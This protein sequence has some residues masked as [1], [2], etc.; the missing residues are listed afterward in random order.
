MGK[1]YLYNIYIAYIM[2]L[3]LIKFQNKL[4]TERKYKRMDRK[5]IREIATAFVEQVQKSPE[6]NEAKISVM[7]DLLDATDFAAKAQLF[8]MGRRSHDKNVVVTYQ[9]GEPHKDATEWLTM[10][11]CFAH[12]ALYDSNTRAS[13]V[14]DE[15]INQ[16]ENRQKL[17]PQRSAGS[18][19]VGH[20][21]TGNAARDQ[22]MKNRGIH[23]NS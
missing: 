22:M 16:V 4:T 11:S 1:N 18:C 10:V 17:N 6:L 8:A 5:Q 7:V 2:I 15:V 3:G 12:W 9:N 13:V 21:S 23:T 20:Q 19:F 14:V